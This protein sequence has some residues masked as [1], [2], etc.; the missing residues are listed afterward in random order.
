MTWFLSPMSQTWWKWLI[1]TLSANIAWASVVLLLHSHS[2]FTSQLHPR[3]LHT[4]KSTFIHKHQLSSRDAQYDK[5]DLFLHQRCS[6]LIPFKHSLKG[7]ISPPELPL[8]PDV[9]GSLLHILS[10]ETTQ[11][12][13]QISKSNLA[14][15]V[16]SAGVWRAVMLTYKNLI[17]SVSWL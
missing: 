13:P 10:C 7:F 16:I 9:K 12:H 1:C 6:T 4:L 8:H 15:V 17:S 11:C 14:T 5:V 2:T 3:P